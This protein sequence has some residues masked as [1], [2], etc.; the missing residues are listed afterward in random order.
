M[1]FNIVLYLVLGLLVACDTTNKADS[2]SDKTSQKQ[3]TPPDKNISTKD[4]SKKSPAKDNTA[5]S[6]KQPS[7]PDNS[8]N[9][10][11]K[12]NQPGDPSSAV[13]A[14]TDQDA[15][16]IFQALAP[17]S[18]ERVLI[19]RA[20]DYIVRSKKEPEYLAEVKT[21]QGQQEIKSSVEKVMKSGHFQE[22]FNMFKKML[23]VHRCNQATLEGIN[24]LGFFLSSQI[25]YSKMTT[26]E[27]IAPILSLLEKTYKRSDLENIIK[28]TVVA[29]SLAKYKSDPSEDVKIDYDEPVQCRKIIAKNEAAFN[30]CLD[31]TDFTK[32]D[33]NLSISEG[34]ETILKIPMGGIQYFK[35]RIM[36]T[37]KFVFSVVAFNKNSAYGNIVMP[38]D[39]SLI[40]SAWST[41][42]AATY[43]NNLT[44]GAQ[45][46]GPVNYGA[47]SGRIW[48]Q[49]KNWTNV[50][51][52]AL[53][54]FESSKIKGDRDSVALVFATEFLGRVM[55]Y[56]RDSSELRDKDE[57]KKVLGD[58]DPAKSF[59]QVLPSE[60]RKYMK[61]VD[62]HAL[63]EMHFPPFKA[64]NINK[65]VLF[66]ATYDNLDH[67]MKN[68]PESKFEQV[69]FTPGQNVEN[70]LRLNTKAE[71]YSAP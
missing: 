16:T 52:E 53:A 26:S 8:S 35:D 61:A 71:S 58:P 40:K 23:P 59:E 6:N 42:V 68:I 30:A 50:N 67:P 21:A 18:N 7:V 5:G 4:P 49:G 2:G 51:N 70:Q 13:K 38:L 9:T 17:M 14:K 11:S 60:I 48:V 54:D 34:I 69:M 29:Y 19:E 24:K 36:G 31:K 41:P 39:A 62:S 43:F 27:S 46:A 65:V 63:I 37:D 22:I 33:E 66:S 56:H 32:N 57:V 25:L 1:R 10:G 47:L 12:K 3:P 64:E 45:L 55:A 28:H 20:A 44:P 15:W